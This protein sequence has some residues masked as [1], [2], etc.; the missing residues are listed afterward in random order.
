MTK[1]DLADKLVSNTNLTKSQAIEAIEGLMQATAD[2][3]KRGENIYLRGFGTFRIEQ[4][5]EKKAR[6]I[7]KGTC[8]HIPAHRVVKFIPCNK[9]KEETK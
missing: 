9:L 7:S 8:V 3:F 5:A 6:N 2:A 1:N 4:R